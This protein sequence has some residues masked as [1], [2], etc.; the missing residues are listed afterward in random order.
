MEN[1]DFSSDILIDELRRMLEEF[2]LKLKTGTADVDNFITLSEIEELMGK[3]IS[4][5]RNL[6]SD[7]LN[8]YIS[9]IDERE[10]LRKKKENTETEE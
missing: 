9:S 5:T 10:L 4:D 2:A 8:E 6:Y 1:K 3:L 7:M